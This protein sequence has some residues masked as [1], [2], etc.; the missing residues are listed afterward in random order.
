LDQDHE[1]GAARALIEGDH[2][3]GPHNARVVIVEYGD[4]ECPACAQAEPL[5]RLLLDQ[6]P[7]DA[8]I[9]FRHFPLRE[10]HPNA[11]RAAEAAEAAAAQGKFWEM[12]DTLFKNQLDLSY[13]ALCRYAN[14]LEL[15]MARFERELAE[16]SYRQRVLDDMAS[17]NAKGVRATPGFF[18]NDRL[19]DASFGFDRL[20]E[21]VRKA[22]A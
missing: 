9:V 7:H 4:F 15:D 18:L 20:A 14:A 3:R 1:K 8:C 2:L 19:V 12:A 13:A 21:A 6:H 17:G 16:H 22:M 5:I 11:E 10:V